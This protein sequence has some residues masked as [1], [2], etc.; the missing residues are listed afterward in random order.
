MVEVGSGK[1][2]ERREGG[3][4]GGCSRDIG[5]VSNRGGADVLKYSSNRLLPHTKLEFS[6]VSFYF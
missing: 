5:V 4:G 6:P 3:G 1:E 2:R